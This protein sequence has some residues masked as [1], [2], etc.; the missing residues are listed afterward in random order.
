MCRSIQYSAVVIWET[1]KRQKNLSTKVFLPFRI[2]DCT[3]N[4]KHQTNNDH[5]NDLRLPCKLLGSLTHSPQSRDCLKDHYHWS[6]GL[7]QNLIDKMF[8]TGFSAQSLHRFV[9]VPACIIIAL[10]Q[11]LLLCFYFGIFVVLLVCEEQTWNWT[12]A[13][14][15][16]Y[17]PFCRLQ[18]C[19][20]HFMFVAC[21]IQIVESSQCCQSQH[22]FISSTARSSAKSQS[23]L[24]CHNIISPISVFTSA[25]CV[26]M[27]YTQV[28]KRDRPW[29]LG[30]SRKMQ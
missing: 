20:M 9:S 10:Q 12:L 26:S 28:R 29:I 15:N 21:Q 25:L 2:A 1:W 22:K 24:F 14:E 8:Y 17:Q 11:Q 19:S 18:G 5:L 23:F 30:Q 16:L 4:G 27:F 6:Q 13:S 7:V 3:W